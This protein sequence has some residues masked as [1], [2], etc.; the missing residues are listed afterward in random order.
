[1][2]GQ[3]DATRRHFLVNVTREQVK[4][5][6]GPET[7]LPV[8]RQMET[9][10]YRHYGW[11]PY[12]DLGPFVPMGPATAFFPPVAA[13]GPATDEPEEPSG[14]PHLHSIKEVTG[15]LVEARDG[16]VGQVQEF[17]VEDGSWAI[18][19][20]VIDAKTWWPGGLVLVAPQWITDIKWTEQ[21][22]HIDQS[23]AQVK[24]APE[25]HPHETVTRDFEKR[26]FDA[27]GVNPYWTM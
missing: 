22:I 13:D 25:Y 24:E 19:Y 6:P 20:A 2:F 18:R 3:P 5:S 1:V 7:A 8:S 17:L 14:D 21:R 23:R 4:H 27:Y 10:L 16:H 11:T 26:L 15:Y 12:W 9:W